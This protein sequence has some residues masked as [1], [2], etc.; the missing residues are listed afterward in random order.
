MPKITFA[1]PAFTDGDART[2]GLRHYGLDAAASPLPSE[3]DRNFLL[4]TAGGDRYVLKISNAEEDPR[5]IDLQNAAL[6]HL[7]TV[8]PDVR[9][10]RVRHTVDG[11]AVASV[12]G[13][14]GLPHLVRLLAWVPGRVLAA[15]R[16]HTPELLQQSRRAARHDGRR[17]GLV[18]APRGGA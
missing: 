15:V 9:L 8:A 10:P 12:L 5:V 16:P 6:L 3:R 18:H 17:A 1:L 13:A 2:I 11:P 4:T 14:E 7:A